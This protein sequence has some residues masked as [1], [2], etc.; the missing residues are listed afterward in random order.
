[1]D[2][3]IRQAQNIVAASTH[4]V[5]LTGA[6]I[7]TPSGIPDFRSTDSGLWQRA[8]PMEV[9]SLTGFKYRPQ[10]FYD[11]I[12]PL[13]RLIVEAEPNPAHYALARL[14]A[15]GR[16]KGVITQ[17]ID[18]LHHRAGSQAV[19]ELHGHLR[20]ATCMRC[21]QI[22]PAGP[23]IDRFLESADVPYCGCGGVLKP[24]VILFGE[25]LPVRVLNEAKKQTRLC[26]TMLVAGSSLEVAPAGDL[27]ILAKEQGAR[28]IIVNY[29][30][31]H[32]DHLADLVIRADVA[33]CLP[34]LVEP[35][36]P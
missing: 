9:A 35:F 28:L 22:F 25:Q 3:L 27:P 34:R 21:Y 10:D 13:V 14:E 30:A 26:D 18:M 32:I 19:Y 5:A 23:I 36:V 24:N 17:N 4:L 8:N 2:N 6:G 20:E 33:E 12:Y 11:W 15:L 1:M 7:S 16:L 31:T 29:E